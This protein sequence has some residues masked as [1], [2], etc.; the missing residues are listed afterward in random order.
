LTPSLELAGDRTVLVT[1]CASTLVAGGSS[2]NQTTCTKPTSTAG[3]PSYVNL[4]SFALVNF[5]ADYDFTESFSAAVGVTN[6]LDQN[7]S[8][9]EGFP[10][11]GRQFYVTARAKF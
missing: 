9:A 7:Y 8:L 1:S 4:G 5:R 10:E 6:L 3:T 2:N 11:A